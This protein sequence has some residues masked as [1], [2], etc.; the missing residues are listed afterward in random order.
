M[1]YT[2]TTTGRGFDLPPVHPDD[3]IRDRHPLWCP[4][5]ESN[6]P[7]DKCICG[8]LAFDAGVQTLMDR[9]DAAPRSDNPADGAR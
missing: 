6:N 7:V 9:I 8:A 2:W 1:S 4:I 5:W 3:A